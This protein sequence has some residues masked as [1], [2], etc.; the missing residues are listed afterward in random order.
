MSNAIHDPAEA[1][2][3]HRGRWKGIVRGGV[4]CHYGIRYA[5]LSNPDR[6]D[7]RSEAASGR[8][9]VADMTE[10]PV[11]PQLPSR[12]EAVTG[13]AAR[14][15][16]QTDDAFF[17]NVWAPTG[18]AGEAQG[19]PVVVF[20]HGGA[21]VS[22]G[23]AVRWYRGEHLARDGVVVVTVNYRLGPAGHLEG[24]G[25]EAGEHR[26]FRDLLLALQWVKA[27]VA[28]FGGDPDRVTLAGQ[29]AGAWYVWALSSLPEAEGLFRRAAILS[30]P[31]IEPWTRSY[32][33]AFSLRVQEFVPGQGAQAEREEVLRAGIL[34]LAEV[35][36]AVGSIS[37]MYLPTLTGEQ[38]ALL[39]NAESAA[40]HQH[41]D[42]VY[43]RITR[44][45]MSVFLPLEASGA[46][47]E[48]AAQEAL[49][50]RANGQKPPLRPVP[51][52]WTSSY[53]EK[54]RLSSWLQFERFSRQIL[55]AARRSGR[56]A[57]EREFAAMAGQRHLGAV[58]CIDLP[59]QFGNFDDWVDAP[60]LAGWDRE[61]FEDL[62]RNV[63]NDLVDF[64]YGRC[65]PAP[66]VFGEG[67][68][69][70]GGARQ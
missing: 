22:G 4:V 20:I 28:D 36:R 32:R 18:H 43:V 24:D 17:L 30:I 9:D 49:R 13:P 38:A 14:L 66:R 6:A 34:A 60:M 65:G 70:A 48:K 25:G 64:A 27:H 55:D 58:H 57:I 54:V 68:G 37:P 41:V 8:L 63:R 42:A 12:L 52:H 59:F 40:A 50:K 1:D 11:F 45:E 53:A 5:R 26:P 61:A 10:V 51:A 16:P 56:E 3:C 35:P 31:E 69:P 7:S 21:W 39:Q 33:K 44:H 62:S 47:A 67:A 15:N 19:L 23:G 46:L 2:G 29:S